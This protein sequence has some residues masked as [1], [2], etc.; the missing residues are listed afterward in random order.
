MQLDAALMKLG[1]YSHLAFTSKNGILAV[2]ERL[3]EMHGGRPKLSSDRQLRVMTPTPAEAVQARRQQLFWQPLPVGH[4]MRSLLTC[5]IADRL[6]QL[7]VLI[8]SN[9]LGAVTNGPLFL[10][11]AD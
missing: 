4:V 1:S 6:F 9:L 2:L 7:T 3:A 11:D 5:C 10:C 8:N